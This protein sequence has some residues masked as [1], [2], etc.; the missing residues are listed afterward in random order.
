MSRGG[1]RITKVFLDSRMVLPDGSLQIPGGGVLLDPSNR[2]WLGEFSTVASWDTVDYSNGNLYILERLGLVSTPRLVE[3]KWGPYDLDTLASALQT[4]LNGPGKLAHLGTYSVTRVSTGES[5]AT[6][7]MVRSYQ[8]DLS[9][10][11]FQIP[12]DEDIRTIW[13]CGDSEVDTR[14]MNRLFRFTPGWNWVISAKS[15]FVDFRRCHKVFIHTP[16]FG[17]YNSIG[18]KGQ[19]DILAKVPVDVGYGGAIHWYMSGSEHESVECGVN[20]LTVLKVQLKDV[21]GNLIDLEGGQ[22]SATLIF[23]K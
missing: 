20:S 22:W 7:A 5:A 9:H 1:E 6:G 12:P 3:P 10:G 21:D 14:S 16:G 18:P 23:D 15:S 8:I 2:C 11:D 4:A 13:F 19:R 17:N